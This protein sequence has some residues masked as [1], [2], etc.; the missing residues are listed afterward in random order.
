M[1]SLTL[2]SVLQILKHCPTLEGVGRSY[3]FTKWHRNIREG[4][5]I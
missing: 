5:E 2:A 4:T 1:L 3:Q